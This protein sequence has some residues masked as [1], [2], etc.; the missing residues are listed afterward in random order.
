MKRFQLLGS[1]LLFLILGACDYSAVYKDYVDIDNGV[2]HVDSVPTFEFTI[3]D[4]TK[5]YQVDY[6]IRYTVEYPFRNLYITYSLED[7][8]GNV[9]QSDLQEINL[10]ESKTGEPLGKGLG[11]IFNIEVRGISPLKVDAAGEYTIKLRQFMR[12][13]T[14]DAIMSVGIVVRPKE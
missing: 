13:E 2:W 3:V 12:R 8:T 14:L 11:D 10:F 4:P 5:E 6:N 1:F 7:S 9:L